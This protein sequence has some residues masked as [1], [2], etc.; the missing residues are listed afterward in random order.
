MARSVGRYRQI[1]VGG[2]RV[3]SFVPTPLP[4]RRP[5]L[6]I[7]GRLGER[8]ADAIAALG[9]LD[10]AG[11]MVPDVDWFL[12]GFLRKEAVVS[13]QIEGTQATLMDVVT[14]EATHEAE[15][16]ADVEE[17]SDY[18][19]ALSY[20][21]AQ[22][23]EAKGLPISVRLLCQTHKRLMRGVRGAGRDPGR[24]RTVQNWVGGA[25]PGLA[26]FIPPPPEAVPEALAALERW[27]HA[28]DPLPP[29]VRVGLAH[30]QFETIHP[31]LDGNGRIGR[32][33]ITF[34]LCHEGILKEP[35]LYLS[36]YF[37][38]HRATYYELLDRVRRTGEWEAWLEFYLDGVRETAD[39]AAATAQRLVELFQRDRSRIEPVGRRAGSALRVLDAFTRRPITTLR[40]LK[41]LTGLSFPTAG[42]AVDLLVDLGV[43]RELTGKRRNR[44]FAYE[45]YI[46][47][48]AE[49][50]ELE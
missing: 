24:L 20:A 1:D 25:T 3:R 18:V 27:I 22:V 8:H 5:V 36:L 37:K 49:G 11:M 12:Y 14:Y 13:S 32:L 15:R 21:R 33:L 2:E 4:P 43:A 44:V 46:R 19:D 28:D 34:L 39:G 23:A 7:K 45:R 30:V 35:L 10:V 9:R 40:D 17:V 6:R 50:T 38:Q 47:I 16:P 48:L 42:A 31:F 29:L 26:T 41:R